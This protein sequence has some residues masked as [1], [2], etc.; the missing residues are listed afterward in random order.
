MQRKQ[1]AI[2]DDKLNLNA[3]QALRHN[4]INYKKKKF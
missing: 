1:K 3:T 2:K 4:Q